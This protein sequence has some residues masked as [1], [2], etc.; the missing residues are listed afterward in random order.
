MSKFDKFTLFSSSK[1]I[2]TVKFLKMETI[3]Q[4]QMGKL[5]QIS[6]SEIFGNEGRE[7]LEG[8]LVTVT[9]VV[10]TPDLALARGYLSI[11]NT[12]DPKKILDFI[13]INKKAIRGILGK[14]IKNKVRHIPNLDFY[15]DD[16]LDE[17]F[18]LEQIF[19]EIHEKEN[20]KLE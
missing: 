7:I 1:T 17:V 18:K 19:K 14:K 10:M 4:K 12:P 2:F 6:L 9:H 20:K 13:T 3:K 11:Y 5:I 8:S 16:T 15:I